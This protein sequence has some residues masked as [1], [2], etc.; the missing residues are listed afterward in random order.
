[1]AC[2]PAVAST[3]RVGIDGASWF[4]LQPIAANKKTRNREAFLVVMRTYNIPPERFRLKAYSYYSLRLAPV[5]GITHLPSVLPLSP[6]VA[7][8]AKDGIEEKQGSRRD[9]PQYHV[10]RRS[11]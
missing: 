3:A 1:M 7:Q 5:V 2:W 6:P 11:R 10:P 8:K 4:A 9:W